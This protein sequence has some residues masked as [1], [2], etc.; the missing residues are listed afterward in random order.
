MKAVRLLVFFLEILSAVASGLNGSERK[1]VGFEATCFSEKNLLISCI[2]FKG[3]KCFQT[4]IRHSYQTDHLPNTHAHKQKQAYQ[5]VMVWKR[6]GDEDISELLHQDP[7]A[8]QELQ[9]R[10]GEPLQVV[11]S[12]PIK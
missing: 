4:R 12:K 1:A 11:S 3:R 10:H 2:K 8:V 7:L 5:T 6:L 9:V